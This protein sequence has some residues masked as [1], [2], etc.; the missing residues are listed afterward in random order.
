VI[1]TI[2]HGS[3]EVPAEAPARALPSA[4]GR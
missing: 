3:A 2:R 1:Q 4:G